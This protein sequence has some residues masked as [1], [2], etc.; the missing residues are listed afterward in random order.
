MFETAMIERTAGTIGE[1]IE[2][3]RQIAAT[4][5]PVVA[6]AQELWFRGQPKRSFELLPGLYRPNTLRYHFHEPSLFGHFKTLAAPYTGSR[7][8]DD[9]EWCFLA[10]HYGL[11]TRC[12]NAESTKLRRG[13]CPLPGRTSDVEVFTR[14][15]RN[16][17]WARE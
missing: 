3:T 6:D 8:V 4:W 10:Q 13:H 12:R 11:P 16:G 5:C 17:A 7:P 15:A 14:A 1:L 2:A 9:W